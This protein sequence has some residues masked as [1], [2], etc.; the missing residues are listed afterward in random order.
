MQ[1][2]PS[3]LPLPTRLRRLIAPPAALLA[4]AA[5]L[6]GTAPPVAA[7]KTDP[8]G[9]ADAAAKPD[10]GQASVGPQPSEPNIA[11]DEGSAGRLARQIG[12]PV[13]IASRRTE[14]QQVFAEPDGTERLVVTALPTR[15][16]QGKTWVDIDPTL[17]WR[18]D[19]TVAP[20][21]VAAE[22]SFSGGGTGPLVR[23]AKDG[24]AL[25]YTWP[26]P[27]PRPTLNGPTATYPDVF[28]GVDLK[29]TADSQG[30]SQVLVVRN[31]EAAAD[32]RLAEL[33]LGVQVAGGDLH[34]D[35]EGNVTLIAADGDVAF[36]GNAP[37]MWDSAG[38]AEEDGDR[39]AGPNTGDNVGTIG[40]RRDGD[41]LVLTPDLE[42][43]RDPA[44]VFPIHIDPPMHGA[45]RLAF[46]YVSKH[47]SNTKYYGTSDVAKVGY[48]DDP[49]ASPT[50]DTYR[51]FF[52]MNTSPVNG[53]HIIKATFR[54]YETWSWSC[55]ARAV[56]LWLTGAIGTGT[57][58][59]NQPSWKRQ[60][61]SVSV[62]KG[63]N[64]SCPGGGVD[65]NATSAVEEAASKNW[66]NLTLGLRAASESDKLGWKKFRNNPVL[67]IT[68]NTTPNVPDQ[69][70][71]EVGASAGVGCATGS[72]APYIT[73]T[74]PTLRARV[75]DPDAGK[76]QTVRAQFEWH[77]TGG[78]KIGERTTS[79]V[80][81]GTSVTAPIPAGA[82][83][84]GGRYSWRVRAQDG[85][86][87]ENGGNSAWS[88]WCDL[89]VDVSRPSSA[90]AV[91]SADYPET[92][93][94]GDPVPAGGVGR[95][96]VF[97][98]APGP[99]DTDIGGFL[100][101][102]NQDDPG[103]A[104]YVAAGADGTA[105]I[106]VTPTRDLLNTLYVW[107]RDKA[108]HVGPFRRYEFSV[109]PATRPVAH[110][111]MDETD[112]TQAR[113]SSGNGHH[114][115]LS[116][117]ARWTAG[118]A[119]GAVS[120][121]AAGA[122]VA[123]ATPNPVI[124][125]DQ[126]F[127]VAAWVRL[128]DKSDH[129]TIL[130]QDS[131]GRSSFYL[132]Y[133]K[134]HDR[135][136]FTMWTAD[137]K[138]GAYAV[139]DA[140]PRIGVWTHLVGTFDAA[141]GQMKLYVNGR[142][143]STVAT[144]TQPWQGTGTLTIGRAWNMRD[145]WVGDADDLRVYDRVIYPGE[146]AN[147]AN[148]PPLLE[149]HWRFDDGSGTHIADS[150][151]NNRHGTANAGVTLTGD[152]WIGGA[153]RFASGGAVV[154]SG[155]V[156][157][158][159]TGFTVAAWV[160]LGDTSATRTV[161]SQDGT[162]RSGFALRYDKGRDRWALV[163]SSADAASGVTEYAATSAAA[164]RAGEWTHLAASYDPA[165]G[166]IQLYVNGNL[167]GTAVDPAGWSADGVFAIGRGFGSADPFV[168]DV[169]DVRA[170]TGVLTEDEIFD[171]ALQ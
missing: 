75:S 23:V 13:E 32:P 17:T 53:K 135:W 165:T 142:A 171:L 78:A 69:L 151:G 92:P 140:P 55:T 80:T 141:T 9:P 27:L 48:Y 76:G 77:H 46:A 138:T 114:A 117:G 51:S 146:I 159:D 118:R 113:D 170:Y 104:T 2:I 105:R 10:P 148:R 36:H 108:G 57:T 47:F 62:A 87:E 12:V 157:R 116:D 24:T 128:T 136:S 83:T 85:E 40:I 28:P 155:P 21:A 103:A 31:A 37:R 67:E 98:L 145:L 71:T 168:G 110:W 147:L 158:T 94:G 162:K 169:D 11:P 1:R 164:P 70:S 8:P 131:D 123:L 124:R 4:C 52:R 106:K 153:G 64:S 127:S 73:T 121:P 79:Y 41:T 39:L 18:G 115:V 15:V 81:S 144:Q 22:V 45:G 6:V 86:K 33:R 163:R 91:S 90:P 66:S 160:R 134:G 35:K 30:F 7:A 102:L 161:L 42:F 156:L 99:G 61:S 54:T 166:R 96:G 97:T 120:F 100:Y 95:M 130:S 43:L 74:T 133:H 56:Q 139:S 154:T 132:Q 25:S 59:S 111:T 14:T 112:G 89:I 82:F 38:V 88:P 143:Q 109:A 44:R 63:Y 20:V 84:D 3:L 129:R 119:G 152:G 93:E 65:F 101:A 58:W 72:A 137:D 60:I 26:A 125:T 167:E 19:G 49:K 29:L 34:I 68:Y 122:Q 16:Q 150:S 126:N 5:L 107:S 149:G 50:K